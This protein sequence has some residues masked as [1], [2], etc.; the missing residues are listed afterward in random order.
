MSG[1]TVCKHIQDVTIL[2][3]AKAYECEECIKIGSGWV[4]LRTCQE[5]GTTLCCDASPNK[6]MTKHH[7]HTNHPVISSAERGEQW[8]FCYPDQIFFEYD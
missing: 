6:H 7:L 2:K 5:C 4:H 1:T 3:E 8:L